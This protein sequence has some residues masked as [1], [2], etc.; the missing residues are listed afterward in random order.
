MEQQPGSPTAESKSPDAPSVSLPTGDEAEYESRII[1]VERWTDENHPP[2]AGWYPADG[3]VPEAKLDVW[4]RVLLECPQSQIVETL[5][6]DQGEPAPTRAGW[7]LTEP[8]TTWS[9]RILW[10]YQAAKTDDE[11]PS[12]SGADARSLDLPADGGMSY[13]PVTGPTHPVTGNSLRAWVTLALTC[14]IIVV[15]LVGLITKV[16]TES[17]TTYIAP[18]S[19]LAGTALG[20]WFGSEAHRW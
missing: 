7:R 13:S 10:Q 14:A 1:V 3:S 2:G 19:A 17:F 8:G 11:T 18:L 5:T 16:P 6:L 12:A 20:F 9:Q 15:V 4:Q